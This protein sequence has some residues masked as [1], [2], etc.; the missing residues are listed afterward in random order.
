MSDHSPLKA[1]RGE[2]AP[3][4]VLDTGWS[5]PRTQLQ[6]NGD[7]AGGWV[8]VVN[9][10]C[11]PQEYC[12]CHTF[13]G[14]KRLT[15]LGERQGTYRNCQTRHDRDANSGKNFECRS[16]KLFKLELSSIGGP[17]GCL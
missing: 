17:N 11:S 16:L 7:G 6:Y 14:P 2:V 13:T 1:H 3:L 8:K 15:D 4:D 10:A 9:E 5:M 12:A